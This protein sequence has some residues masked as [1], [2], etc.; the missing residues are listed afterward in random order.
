MC[1]FAIEN[2]IN[3]HKQQSRASMYKGH[4]IHSLLYF[5]FVELTLRYVKN[6]TWQ[7][8]EQLL[9]L[10]YLKS[11]IYNSIAELMY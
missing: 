1:I 9:L 8:P 5:E 7:N 11:Y 10:W 3:T 6:L 2:V 4:W